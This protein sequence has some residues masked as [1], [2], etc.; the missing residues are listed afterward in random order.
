MKKY[1]GKGTKESGK[2]FDQF[3]EASRQVCDDLDVSYDAIKAERHETP[4]IG[5]T[6]SARGTGD[7]Y[8]FDFYLK[9]DAENENV[10]SGR[11]SAWL[12]IHY[13]DSSAHFFFDEYDISMLKP[14]PNFLPRWAAWAVFNFNLKHNP[15]NLESLFNEI[16]IRVYGLPLHTNPTMGEAHLL[17]RGINQSQINKLL[18]YKFRHVDP[19]V[20]YRSFSYAFLVSYDNFRDFW[21]FFPNCGGL[22]SGGA[23]GDLYAMEE[24]TKTVKTKV[25]RK[26]F[27]IKYEVLEE[28]LKKNAIGFRT[29]I[30]RD[31]ISISFIEPSDI[32]FGKDFVESYVRFKERFQ[33]EDYAGALRD[34]R[35]TVQDAMEITCDKKNVDLEGIQNLKIKNISDKMITADLIDGAIYNWFLAFSSVASKASHGGYPTKKDLENYTLRRRIM[36]TF[37]LGTHLI[38]ELEKILVPPKP[39]ETVSGKKFKINISTKRVPVDKT[40]HETLDGI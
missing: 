40:F 36:T 19:D 31:D 9:T 30:E 23:S 22:D 38:E 29:E 28:F 26:C 21:V 25:E 32:A 35:A 11:M 10:L 6:Y 1:S 20:K 3:I 13:S 34:L 5:I 4:T 37:I 17:V 16:D 2:L 14:H 39:I 12:Q 33:A 24:L 8:G 15:V 27:D 18:V 7:N